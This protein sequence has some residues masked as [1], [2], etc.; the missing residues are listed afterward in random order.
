MKHLRAA[1]APVVTV[2]GSND[3][4]EGGA[5]YE[6]ARAVGRVLAEMGFA[7][8]NGGYGG[9]MEAAARGA[10][11]AGGH[12]IGV[13]CTVW[14][15]RANRHIRQVVVTGSPM[16]RL[17][18]LIEL[19]TGGYVVLRGA[20]GTLAELAMVW[21]QTAKGLLP[22]RPIICVGDFWR[23]LL[24]L[25]SAERPGTERFVTAIDRP[26]GLRNCLA[27]PGR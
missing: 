18:R 4:A 21:E 8:A 16:E 2:F 5:A 9:T 7:V 14:S 20:T 19:G 12:T 22:R 3:A 10:A 26:E 6:E 17:A 24:G 15:S 25:M 1:A 23:P 13:V 27:K 11:E